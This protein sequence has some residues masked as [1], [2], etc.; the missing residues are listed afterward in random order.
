MNK[1]KKAVSFLALFV[2]TLTV[3]GCNSNTAAIVNG[4]KITKAQF[5]RAMDQK[6][7]S[8]ELQGASFD[9]EQGKQMVSALEQQTIEELIQETLV[10]QAV[11]KEKLKPSDKEVNDQ[12]EALKK[13]YGGEEE[14]AKLVKQYNYTVEE[15]KHKLML[16]LAFNK[17]Y[18]KVTA[19]VKVTEAD[20]K[21]YYE[22][23]TSQFFVPDQIKARAILVKYGAS[24]NDP[25]TGQPV[26][27]RAEKDALKIANDVIAKLNAGEDFA[28]LAEQYSEDET[29]KKDGGLIKDLEGKSPYSK[30]TVMPAEFDE[31]ALALKDG[32]HSKEPVKTE[33]GY[34]IIKLEGVTP[35]KQLSYEEAKE[36]I[37][38]N[39]PNQRKQEKFNEYY[40]KLEKE[41][42][43]EN[44]I[45]GKTPDTQGQQ[46][47]GGTGGGE[48]QQLP[49]GHPSVK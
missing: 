35:E 42:K 1:L 31:A 4:E 26:P 13:Q 11:E 40:T 41:A 7:K 46:T 49:E 29:S 18:E 39:L 44:K 17:L 22:Q 38:K 12:L 24:G 47:P 5:N 16:D 43:I 19:D 28:K 14:F 10:M 33:S 3:F 48:G 15:T 2:F 6:K 23:N 30:N 34:Y 36:T 27:G 20:A 32:Q 21:K 25:M 9:S 8:L 45:S 37:M